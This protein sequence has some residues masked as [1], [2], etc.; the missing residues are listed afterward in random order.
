MDSAVYWAFMIISKE[1]CLDNNE[2]KSIFLCIL[3]N[4][5]KMWSMGSH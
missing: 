2:M 5:V 3:G 1:L 4:G